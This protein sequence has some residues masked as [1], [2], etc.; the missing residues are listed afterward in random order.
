MMRA[1]ANHP[2]VTACW[3]SGGHL[4]YRIKDSDIIHRVFTLYD[5]IE[6]IIKL[7]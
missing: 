6:Y 5:D 3:A 1:I 2:D 7:K 4:R